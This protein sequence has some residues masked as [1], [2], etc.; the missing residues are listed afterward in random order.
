MQNKE[1]EIIDRAVKQLE[2]ATGFRTTLHF[3]EQPDKPDAILGLENKDYKVDF[4][5]EVK[6]FLNRARLGLVTNQLKG[7]RGIPLLITEYVNPELMETIE[8]YGINFI[9]ATG[10]AYIKVPPLFIKIKG[11]KREAK[12]KN[13]KGI[14]NTA[15]L[16]T[17][18][19]IL[20]NPELEKNPIREIAN[21]ANVAVGTVHKTL[22]DLQEQ[23]YLITKND[24]HVLVNKKDLLERWVTLYPERLK[25]KFW[26]GRYEADEN[27]IRNLDLTHFDA[28]LGGE[29]A[30]EK[31]T[32][33]LHAYI[34]TIYIG[35]HQGEFILRNRL[36]KDPKGNLILMKKFW[37]Y[38]DFGYNDITHPILVYA[39]LLATG[40]PRN[41]ETA[42]II[43]ETEIVRYIK[44]N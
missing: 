41:I 25:P 42:K 43:Y 7:M 33:Y 20:C 6:I 1:K 16:Q 35:G 2:K 26:L 13:N 9:D 32:D 18:F 11:N 4:E 12:K 5:V 29:A 22:K 40:D 21:M 37:N 17:I 19:T 38:K 44:E 34:Y 31:M 28:Q 14:V 24:E 8:D 23:G 3:Y 30:A 36:R 39:D 27:Q 15:A 10:N